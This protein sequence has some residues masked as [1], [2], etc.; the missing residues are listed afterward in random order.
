VEQEDAYTSLKLFGFLVV[1]DWELAQTIGH[2]QALV[3]YGCH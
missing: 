1:V 3:S 2:N